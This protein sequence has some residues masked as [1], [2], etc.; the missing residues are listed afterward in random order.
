MIRVNQFVARGRHTSQ[1]PKPRKWILPLINLNL[2]RRHR[3]TAYSVKPIAPGQEIARDLMLA[4][5]L[6]IM[7]SW[8]RLEIGDP[9][10]LRLK[11]NRRVIPE[12]RGDQILQHFLLRINGDRL[13]HQVLKVN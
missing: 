1:Y 7:N 13:S 8:P 5:V 3:R 9:H 12:P 11:E 4:A 2:A 6:H 10:G